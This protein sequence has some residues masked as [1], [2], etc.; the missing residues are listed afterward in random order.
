[1]AMTEQPGERKSRCED[2]SMLWASMHF[3]AASIE[4]SEATAMGGM[5]LA[6]REVVTVSQRR[7]RGTMD[8]SVDN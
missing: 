8:W 2:S 4:R 1:M 3:N 6:C 7:H 5:V